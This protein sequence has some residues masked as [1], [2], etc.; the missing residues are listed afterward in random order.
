VQLCSLKFERYNDESTTVRVLTYYRI[1]KN[2]VA[3]RDKKTKKIVVI[4]AFTQFKDIEGNNECANLNKLTKSLMHLKTRS[5][6][7]SSNGAQRWGKMFA[8]VW[9][10]GTN[11]SLS[12]RQYVLP[13]VTQRSDNAMEEWQGFRA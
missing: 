12:L 2:V 3:V 11:P 10:G 1:H 6:L 7:V 9:R 13:Q 5:N 4:L 8:L